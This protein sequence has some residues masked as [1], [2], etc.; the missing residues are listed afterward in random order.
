MSDILIRGLFRQPAVR[1]ALTQT[2]DLVAEGIRRH[3]CDPVAGAVFAEALTTTAML[4]V[5]LDENE[6]YSLRLGYTGEVGTILTDVNSRGDVRGLIHN[7]HLAEF[8]GDLD[9]I[10][11]TAEAPVSLLRTENGQMRNSGLVQ[12]GLASPAAD[13]AM[14]FSISD[15]IETEIVTAQEFRAD[16]VRPVAAAGGFL[17]QAMPDCD[18]AAFDTM[19][20]KMNTPE[21]RRRLL[22]STPPFEHQ[23]RDLLAQL[24][25]SEPSY[26]AAGVPGFRCHCSR[27]SMARALL[28]LGD[29]ELQKLFDENPH[30]SVRC[31]FCRQQYF[32]RRDDLKHE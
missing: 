27:D 22:D 8:Q 10:F 4:S 7:P 12:C 21:F 13:T 31:Q 6:K 11:G 1:F 24:G 9:R 5:L 18:L 26:S 29:A 32:F 16:P 25:G 2:T 3:D 15:Q 28:T 30:P 20:Q 17:L 19:R 14:F 23:V